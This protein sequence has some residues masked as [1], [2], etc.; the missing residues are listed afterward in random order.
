MIDS[1]ALPWCYGTIEVPAADRYFRSAIE[2][3]GEYG[4]LELDLYRALLAPGDLAIDVG[5][6]VGIFTI[7]MALAVGA[8]GR[9]LAFEPQPPIFDLLGRN[10]AA[11]GL[12]QVEPHRTIVGDHDGSG[13]F[14]EIR[15]IPAGRSVNL[16]GV[17][18]KS[19]VVEQFG[20][21]VPT[22]VRR[23]DSL[24]L[25]RCALI[26]VDVEGDEGA[27]LAGAAATLGRCRPIFS[28]ECD[29]PNASSPWA[30][31]L[32]GAGYRLWRFRGPLMRFPNPLG[33]SIEG[34]D[35][36]LSIMV[37][38]VPEERVDLMRRVDGRS[39]QAVPSRAALEALSRRIVVS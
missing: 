38:A 2:A 27:V 14:V 20:G 15:S 28:L 10:V 11:H 19:R 37:V 33:R 39:L 3:T 35:N 23:L 1:V 16:G 26:K 22:P 34:L 25:D 9:V 24:D 21:M 12:I 32:L 31:T 17:S 7:G 5:A 4:G 18:T 6:N 29:R 13:E 36:P 8:A 30:D